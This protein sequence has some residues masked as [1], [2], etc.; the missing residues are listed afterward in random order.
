[1]QNDTGEFVNFYKPSKSTAEVATATS[2]FRE[3]VKTDTIC[4]ATRRVGESDDSTLRLVK[5]HVSS[6]DENQSFSF[7]T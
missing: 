4:G 1:M 7:N 3:E 2:R 6:L 5:N